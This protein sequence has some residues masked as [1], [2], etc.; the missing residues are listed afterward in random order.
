VSFDLA[1]LRRELA[2]RSGADWEIYAKR[3][4]SREIRLAVG[5]SEESERREEGY[6][7]RWLERGS[8][9]FAAASSP[10]Q[11][12]QAAG[13]ATRIPRMPGPF[14][15]PLPSGRFPEAS[16]GELPPSSELFGPL[17]S[18]LAS[19]SKGQ[20]RLTAVSAADS[21]IVDHLENG[22]G[23]VGGRRRTFGYGNAQAIGVSGDRRVGADIVFLR[24]PALE[25]DLARIA[26][27][28]TDRALLPLK[29][30]PLTFPRGELLLDP[31][32]AAA[33]LAETLPLFCGDAL[34]KT[35]SSRYLDREGRFT[36]EC[37]SLV[38][39]GTSDGPFDGEGTA[40]RR[41]V[42]VEG[43]AFRGPLH[44]LASAARAR[45]TP[46]GNA[47]RD[48]FRHPPRPGSGR[49]FLEASRPA[50]PLQLLERVAR[51]LY[52]SAVISPPRV[53]LEND[54]FRIEVE[55]WSIQ[56]GKAKSPVARAPVSGRLSEFWRRIGAVGTDRRWFFHR[57]RVG[58]PTLFVERA[59]F[60]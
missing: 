45:E 25:P 54:R 10:E 51:G 9:F 43:G 18:L 58:A 59:T 52:A 49:F 55:G 37:V 44:D 21:V 7:A 14:P 16:P 28:L 17:S 8:A 56:A 46:T 29:G 38:D 57:F 19:E 24:E 39:D 5:R 27:D 47:L 30:R 1:Q 13:N 60:S 50:P 41:N 33:L 35:L 11:L 6:A 15:A 2:S 48:S 3:A 20:A 26:R 23:F 4:L 42:V 22:A 40:V 53:D 32:V 12:L 36:S 31:S 34:R